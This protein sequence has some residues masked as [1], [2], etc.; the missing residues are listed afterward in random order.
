MSHYLSETKLHLRIVMGFNVMLR[1][2]KYEDSSAVV[3]SSSP[4]SGRFGPL[5]PVDLPM[6]RSRDR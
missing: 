2:E 1:I 3:W 5:C 4:M 6:E